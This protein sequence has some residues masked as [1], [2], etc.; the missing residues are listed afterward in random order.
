MI[1]HHDRFNHNR[2]RPKHLLAHRDLNTMA[3]NLQLAF[4]NSFFWYKKLVFSNSFSWYKQLVFRFKCRR[5][6]YGNVRFGYISVPVQTMVWWVPNRPQAITWPH[7]SV[8]WHENA[9]RGNCES[10]SQWVNPLNQWWNIVIHIYRHIGGAKHLMLHVHALQ[11]KSEN[12]SIPI[13]T[14]FTEYA[15]FLGRFTNRVYPR[16]GHG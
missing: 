2:L 10:A 13:P 1:R 12:P 5:S 8:H 14:H 3:D 11:F 4:S 9:S 6:R 7:E 16:F 15:I